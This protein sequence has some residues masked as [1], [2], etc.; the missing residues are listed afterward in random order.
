[1]S[2]Q[3]PKPMPISLNG[4]R[5]VDAKRDPKAFKKMVAQLHRQGHT[6]GEIV[7]AMAASQ[8]LVSAFR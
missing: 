4:D 1:M 6:D 2:K 5:L 8:R 7:R 3:K